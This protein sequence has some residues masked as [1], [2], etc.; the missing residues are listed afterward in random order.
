MNCRG[1]AGPTSPELAVYFHLSASRFL[2]NGPRE[3]LFGSM[4]IA[5][6][7]VNRL[8]LS[9]SERTVI[10]KS[11]EVGGMGRRTF[12]AFCSVMTE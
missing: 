2:A 9:W 5:V 4:L 10:S 6:A 8:L 11:T 1:N 3:S 7:H 12:E